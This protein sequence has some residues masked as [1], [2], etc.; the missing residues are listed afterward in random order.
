MNNPPVV[1]ICGSMRFERDMREAAVSESLA[2]AIVLLPLVNM[3]QPDPRWS[4]AAAA[5]RVKIE[6]DR[7]H[8]AKIDAADTVLVVCPGGYIGES[9]GREIAYARATGKP[10]RFCPDTW[11]AAESVAVLCDTTWSADDYSHAE[12]DSTSDDVSHTVPCIWGCGF[13]ATGEA[14]LNDHETTCVVVE[15]GDQR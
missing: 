2:G 15:A 13:L 4:S 14:E 5:E 10:V 11:T 3:K 9:T 8:L 12:D 1:T 6:L 7:L